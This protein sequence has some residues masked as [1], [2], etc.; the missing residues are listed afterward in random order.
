MKKCERCGSTDLYYE[1]YYDSMVCKKCGFRKKQEYYEEKEKEEW[2]PLPPAKYID[3][4][5]FS[6]FRR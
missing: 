3:F 1:Q 2:K 6:A 5:S 4:Y